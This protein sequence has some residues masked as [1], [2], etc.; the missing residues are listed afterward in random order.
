M[1]ETKP[2][3]LIAEMGARARTAAG[4]LAQMTTQEKAKALRSAAQALR[5]AEADILAAN[6]KDMAEGEAKGLTGALLDHLE[7]P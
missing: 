7:Y 6:D 5:D 3:T 2:E 1:L 4:E